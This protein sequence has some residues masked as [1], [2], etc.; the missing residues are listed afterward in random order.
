MPRFRQTAVHSF[1]AFAGLFAG[2]GHVPAQAATFMT[3]DPY[4]AVRLGS[5]ATSADATHEASFNAAAGE[6]EAGRV[7]FVYPNAFVFRGFTATGSANTEIGSLNSSLAAP[8]PPTGFTFPVRS[9]DEDSAYGDVDGDGVYT[10]GSDP[11]I[12]YN[13]WRSGQSL[14]VFLPFGGDLNA[15]TTLAPVNLRIGVRVE[16]GIFTNPADAG[17]YTVSA[18]LTSVDP[19][20]DDLNDGA[21]EAPQTFETSTILEIGGDGLCSTG[22]SENCLQAGSASITIQKGVTDDKDQ[23]KWK[24]G[25]G[26]LFLRSATHDPSDTTEYALC[27]YDGSDARAVVRSTVSVD[28]STLWI[29]KGSKGWSYKDKA[30]SSDGAAKV[31]LKPGANGKSKVQFGAKGANIPMPTP[32]GGGKFFDKEPNVIVQLH[33]SEGVCWSSEFKTATTNDAAKFQAKTP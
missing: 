10:P 9:R 16:E 1:I 31:S 15:A 30:A 20:N 25:K 13:Q 12:E 32:V 27:I 7:E 4:F 6:L 14:T 3:A 5:T 11:R 33:N 29:D 24:W 22:P 26:G 23:I 21:G 17:Q 8:G 18:N 19:D 2:L 28:A